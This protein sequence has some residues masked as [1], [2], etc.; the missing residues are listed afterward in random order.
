VVDAV[1]NRGPRLCV[2]NSSGFRRDVNLV[3]VAG[4][5]GTR[6]VK[7][8]SGR[9]LSLYVTKLIISSAIVECRRRSTVHMGST[10]G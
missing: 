3:L 2:S 9:L 10:K 5:L 8:I 7:V 6:V 4:A 1:E